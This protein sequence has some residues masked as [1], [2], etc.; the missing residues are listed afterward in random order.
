MSALQILRSWL[1]QRYQEHL[2]VTLRDKSNGQSSAVLWSS[3]NK[4]DRAGAWLMDY[5]IGL[6]LRVMSFLDS[7]EMPDDINADIQEALELAT[8]LQPKYGIK[9]DESDKYGLWHVGLVWLVKGQ[10]QEEQWRRAIADFRAESG[11]S[12]EIALDAIFYPDEESFEKELNRHALPGLLLRTRNLFR[13]KVDELPTWLTA[14]EAVRAMLQDL[15]SRFS[16][17]EVR[18]LAAKLVN[19]VVQSP[20]TES[21]QQLPPNPNTIQSLEVERCR[22]LPLCRM[23]FSRAD[24]KAGA[25][26]LFGPNGTGKSTLFEALS[27][28]VCD[29]SIGLKRYLG[30]GDVLRKDNYVSQV[31]TPLSGGTPKIAVNDISW[32]SSQVTHLTTE[33]AKSKL[34]RVDGNLLA[35]EDSREFIKEAGKELGARILAGYSTLADRAQ[36]LTRSAYEGANVRRKDW[37]E[38]YGLNTNITRPE[39]RWRRLAEYVLNRNVPT[40]SV[41]L[42]DWLLKARSLSSALGEGASE[43][44]LRWRKSDGEKRAALAEKIASM[45]VESMDGKLREPIRSWMEERNFLAQDTRQVIESLRP[46]VEALRAEHETLAEEINQWGEWLVRQVK[47]R[48]VVAPLDEYQ[49]LIR[50]VEDARKANE[51]VIKDGMF[52]RQHS[53]HLTKL[54]QEFLPSWVKE[55]P[56][57]CPTCGVDHEADG[58]ILAVVEKLQAS[59]HDQLDAKRAELRQRQDA[60]KLTESRLAAIGEC[61]ISA[62]RRETL[63]AKL[64]GLTQDSTLEAILADIDRR[65]EL[66]RELQAMIVLPIG[67]ESIDDAINQSEKLAVDIASL[68]VEGERIWQEPDNWGEINTTL[69]KECQAIVE[70]HLPQTLEAVWLEIT[71]ALTSA[72]WNLAATP[73]FESTLS[74]GSEKLMIV[75]GKDERQVLARYLFN[76]A[77][78][79]ILGLAWFFTRYLI[80]GRFR[81]ALVAMDDPAQEMDQTTFRAF[82]RFLQALLRLHKRNNQPLTLL[83]FLHQEDRALDAARATGGQFFMLKWEREPGKNNVQPA[84]RQVILLNEGFKPCLPKLPA[85]TYTA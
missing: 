67:P 20:A 30:D 5:D 17:P 13:L 55:R 10:R 53:E 62:E 31:L 23:D 71:F 50:Q 27:F 25:H 34:Q 12:E 14:N 77:E 51:Q 45:G 65:T 63:S 2:G 26:I 43:L 7:G 73:R 4:G 44:A 70:Q 79:H 42:T 85:E 38:R 24:N 32:D 78:Q 3:A 58:G 49:D 80:E 54:Q 15:P 16:R 76:Q 6:T 84:V 47:P 40:V 56:D 48:D 68:N 22:N 29:A 83:L 57:E 74:R 66:Q 81:H 33:T 60:L 61:P 21:T 37:L 36:S 39:K 18:T 35:Q 11:F 75:A 82:T 69:Q 28:G 41:G 59:L 8:R 1:D 9:E 46:N 64:A 19:D 52:L 72:P